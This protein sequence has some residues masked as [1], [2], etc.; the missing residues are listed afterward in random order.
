MLLL[1]KLQALACNFT[2]S[3]SRRWFFSRFVDIKSRNTS[4]IK[5]L[6]ISKILKWYWNGI[7]KSE[8]K[9]FESD[10]KKKLCVVKDY[11][12]DTVK[13]DTN[14]VCNIMLTLSWQWLLS[15][16]NQSIDL[17]SKSMDWFLYDNGL[18]HERVNYLPIKLK[19][20]NALFL[21]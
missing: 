19:S 21:K 9:E 7:F 5:F 17:Q 20:V 14:L 13:I 11:P 15:Y 8:Q 3:N 18:H 4:Q 6:S 16:R 12:T 2:T 10:L 1:V